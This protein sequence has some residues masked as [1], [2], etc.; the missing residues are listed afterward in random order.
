MHLGHARTFWLAQQRSFGAGGRLRLRNDDL[1]QA[2]CRDEFVTAFLK[3]LAWLGLRWEEPIVVQSQRLGLYRRAMRQL[4]AQG[5][6]YPCHRSRK[7]VAEA[8]SAPHENG[9]N[10]E[11]IYPVQWRPAADEIPATVEDHLNCN[12][13][14]RVP[15]GTTISFPDEIQGPQWAVAGR[16][17][18]DFLVWRKDGVP[19]YQLACAFDDGALGINQVV[20]GADLI[21]STFRQILLLQALNYETPTYHHAPLMTDDHGDR[22]AKRTDALS[23]RA[24]REQGVTPSE[25]IAKFEL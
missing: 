12:W 6:I 5:A 1:D 24:L 3:D 21:K 18:G 10:D 19:S 17:F 20:R 11:P 8:A 9:L 2:R 23:L 7:E 13:R 4:H 14:F 22:L 16:D 25:I 15:E